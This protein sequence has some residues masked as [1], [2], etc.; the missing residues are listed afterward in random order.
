MKLPVLGLAATLLVPAMAT[1]PAALQAVVDRA[2]ADTRAEFTAPALQ[3]DQLAVTVVDLRGAA[4]VPASYRGDARMYPASVIKLF[5]AAYAHRL[6]EDGKL[7][8]TPELRRGMRDMIVD[9]YNEATSY[10]VDAITGTT[11]GPELPPDELAKW[12]AQ[13]G[14]VTRYFAGLGYANVY[15]QRKPWGEG[16]YGREKQDMEAHPPARNYLS[17][18]DT[19]RLLVELAQG[20]CVSPAR[21]AQLLE[22]MRRD[23]FKA[24]DDPDSQDVGF[25]GPA[26]SPGMKLWAKAGWV[27]W[28]RHDAALIELPGGGRVVIV[29]FTEGREHANNRRII[30][31]VARRVLAHLP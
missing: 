2:V 7:A 4:P 1:E 12:N 26:L 16:P 27:S 31:A 20:R 3:A 13:R 29:T 21:S 28:A 10:V 14:I 24:S 8:D 23:P 5:F 6:M 9:S 19:A 25:T 15:A 22:L 18:N 30:A 11:S 17:T